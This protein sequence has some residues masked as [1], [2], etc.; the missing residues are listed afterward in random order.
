M[1]KRFVVLACLFPG[2]FSFFFCQKE[3][4]KRL[5]IEFYPRDCKYVIA[6]NSSITVFKDDEF[7]I[8]MRTAAAG[9]RIII[10]I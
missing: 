5:Q 6:D 8:K 2:L 1:E 7:F 9:R 3:E 10:F 4:Y